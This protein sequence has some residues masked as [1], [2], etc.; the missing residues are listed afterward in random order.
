MKKTSPGDMLTRILMIAIAAMM[1][2]LC[3]AAPS[4]ARFLQPD[5]W[6]PWLEGVD[7]N[8]YAYGNSDPINRSDPNG[9]DSFVAGVPFDGTYLC[10]GGACLTYDGGNVAGYNPLTTPFDE[11]HYAQSLSPNERAEYF[12]NTT[13]R[14]AKLQ[15]DQQEAA[16]FLLQMLSR[17]KAKAQSGITPPKN[18]GMGPRK[19]SSTTRKLADEKA[20]DKDGK[21]RC[22]YCK[23]EMTTNPGQK[24][25]REFD[26][27][28]PYAR[29]GTSDPKN[30]DSICRSCN[31]SKGSKSVG[32]FIRS[33]FSKLTG[34]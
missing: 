9:H 17:G 3:L 20:K 14:R 26:H 1:L 28:H 29:G 4:H 11:W 5:N 32:D 6:D 25:S 2:C 31:R 21:L 12:A 24:I 23:E 19:P 27:R 33:L 30:I 10:S 34:G 18:S 16:L 7:I 8:R 13:E 15:Q 22:K